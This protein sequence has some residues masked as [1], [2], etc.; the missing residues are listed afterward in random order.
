M[1]AVKR[2]GILGGMSWVSSLKYYETVNLEILKL[3][4]DTRTA[5]LVLWSFDTTQI[6]PLILTQ[7]LRAIHRHLQHAIDRLMA[8]Q[9]SGRL[10][11]S[12]RAFRGG[13]RAESRRGPGRGG[14]RGRPRGRPAVPRAGAVATRRLP[15]CNFPESVS[16]YA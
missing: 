13:T 2:L 4:G 16:G 8:G 15:R 9:R 10:A 3:T 5:D 6:E 11:M 14:V 1:Y 7:N 12:W